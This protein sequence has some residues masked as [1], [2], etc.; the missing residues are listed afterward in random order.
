MN[1]SKLPKMARWMTTGRCSALSAPDVFQ[2][3]VLRLL[4]VELN[5][6]AL[7]FPA[8]RVGDVEIDLRPVERAVAFVERVG[9]GRARSSAA[10][11]CASA[12]SHV[13]TSPRNSSG[14]VDSF[15]VNGRPKSP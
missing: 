4:V 3:E 11:S 13:A 7:P 6:R 10:L 12:W 2:V 8:D 9:R 1:R 5:R 14:R 15:A